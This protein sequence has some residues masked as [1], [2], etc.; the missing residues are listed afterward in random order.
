MAFA[1][2][3]VAHEMWIEPVSFEIQAGGYLKAHEKVGQKFKGNSYSYLESSFEQFNITQ[4]GKTRPIKSRLGNK[5]VVNEV[6][7]KEGLLIINAVSSGYELT[8]NS[9]EKFENF[10]QYEGLGWVREAHKKRGLPETGFKEFY[11]RYVKSLVKVGHGKGNDKALGMQIE[12]VAET[13]PYSER[14]KTE[15]GVS[16]QLLW[17][18]KPLANTHVNV[19]NKP[20]HRAGKDQTIK[21]THQ[22]DDEGKVFI[23]RAAGGIFLISAVKM[24]EPNAEVK[25][26]TNAVWQSFWASIT[27]QLDVQ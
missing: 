16:L 26:Q 9:K 13:N 14:V 11:K 18:G 10:L 6:I 17:Q 22:T 3:L 12:W 15:K 8:Y 23:P 21:T 20:D 4:N 1:S 19:F 7:D 5:P 2:S 27:Y 25:Q 24:L